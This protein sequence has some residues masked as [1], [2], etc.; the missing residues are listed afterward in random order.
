MKIEVYLP[1]ISGNPVLK[2]VYSKEDNEDRFNY[3]M[4]MSVGDKIYYGSI[5]NKMNSKAYYP[6][7]DILKINFIK[8]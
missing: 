7:T 8:L 2:A 3:L 6:E 5:G 4:G 1:N